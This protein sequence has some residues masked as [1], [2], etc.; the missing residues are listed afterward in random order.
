MSIECHAKCRCTLRSCESGMYCA[1]W[2]HF[3]LVERT[4]RRHVMAELKS[5]VVR[6]WRPEACISPASG[7]HAGQ[8]LCRLTWQPV[9]PYSYLIIILNGMKWNK[10][11]NSTFQVLVGTCGWGLLNWTAEILNILKIVAESSFTQCCKEVHPSHSN[12]HVC[13][14]DIPISCLKACVEHIQLL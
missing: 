3:T 7:L 13:R 2:S 12:C 1:C 4:F 6:A 14:S 11:K 9:T 10:I 5:R 8:C